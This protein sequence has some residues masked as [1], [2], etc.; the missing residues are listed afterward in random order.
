M[1]REGH[2]GADGIMCNDTL[3]HN[4][5]PLCAS[6]QGDATDTVGAETRVSTFKH[7]LLC[8][9]SARIVGNTSCG[10][11]G[12]GVFRVRRCGSGREVSRR[13][14]S[15]GSSAR[16]LQVREHRNCVQSQ[17]TPLHN[18][19]SFL[20]S[21]PLSTNV[22]AISTKEESLTTCLLAL[23]RAKQAKA[24]VIGNRSAKVIGKG[25]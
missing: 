9:L 10:R 3:V 11:H 22:A 2:E 1:A 13:R 5:L 16:Q 14:S 17:D 19:T 25:W 20:S 23:V 21:P 24:S 15:T 6:S 8:V 7:V 4:Y 12:G 18:L